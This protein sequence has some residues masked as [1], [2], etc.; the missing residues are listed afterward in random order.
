MYLH[1]L[2]VLQPLS[3]T[4][5]RAWSCM[6]IPTTFVHLCPLQIEVVFPS[7]WIENPDRTLWEP[8]FL[9]DRFHSR[10][11]Q[12]RSYDSALGASENE[13]YATV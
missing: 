12:N 10:R 13:E 11:V 8:A 6:L 7:Q 1:T 2:A 4:L 9:N 3:L 5:V